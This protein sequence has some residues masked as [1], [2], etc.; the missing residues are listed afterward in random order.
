MN[1]DWTPALL[2]E[3]LERLLDQFEK[4]TL[5]RFVTIEK[6]TEIAFRAANETTTKVELGLQKEIANLSDRQGRFEVVA[7]TH[8]TQGEYRQAHRALEKMITD[9]REWSF[10]QRGKGIAASGIWAIVAGAMA[11][12]IT[13]LH[14]ISSFWR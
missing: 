9:V 14:A 10:E 7:T 3:H 11:L 8:V 5:E 2:K 4:R 12:I 1:S 6:A 13:A